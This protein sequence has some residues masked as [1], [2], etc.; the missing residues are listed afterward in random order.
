MQKR[1]NI[2]QKELSNCGLNNEKIKEENVKDLI[3]QENNTN[4]IN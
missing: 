1:R 3:G 2:E 4:E